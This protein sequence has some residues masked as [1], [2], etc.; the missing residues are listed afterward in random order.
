MEFM[1]EGMDGITIIEH[2]W[3]KKRKVCPTAV[4]WALCIAMLAA[5]FTI[6]FLP[7]VTT[8]SPSTYFLVLSLCLIFLVLWVLSLPVVEP[9]EYRI[10][11][12]E[13]CSAR[14]WNLVKKYYDIEPI[15]NNVYLVQPKYERNIWNN[16]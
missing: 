9:E 8:F 15:S 4:T 12:R 5:M 14:N 11:R 3:S 13:T 10:I 2:N 16:L 1:L 7:M 6:L